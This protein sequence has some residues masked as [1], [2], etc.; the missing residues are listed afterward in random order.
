MIDGAVPF[1]LALAL[2]G[3]LQRNRGAWSHNRAAWALSASAGLTAV[4]RLAGVPFDMGLWMLIDIAVIAVVERGH[5]T[6]RERFIAPLMVLCWTLYQL[7]LN[8]QPLAQPA[9][10][11]IVALQFLLTVPWD[12]LGQR[13][14]TEKTA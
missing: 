2:Y 12:R 5:P 8:G 11:L 14:W 7:Q 9:I 10:T 3:A 6:E 4:L 13:I 1:V